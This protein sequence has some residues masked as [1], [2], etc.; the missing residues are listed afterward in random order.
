[1][2][3]SGTMEAYNIPDKTA[4]NQGAHIITFLEGEIIDFNTHTLETK[5]FKA[6]AEID[7][8]YWRELQ[9]FKSLTDDEIVKNLVSKR[10]LTENLARGWILMRWKERCFVTPSHS[11]QG[12]TIYGFYYISVR[13]DNGH[14]EGMYYDPGSSPYQ[15]LSLDPQL[16]EK[17]VFPA[18]GFR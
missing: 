14:I 2:T 18:Y 7:S 8:T 3:L 11:Q 10:W 12:L 4:T 6:D 13:R 17:M 1:M 9:P 16:K 5:N 15:Q